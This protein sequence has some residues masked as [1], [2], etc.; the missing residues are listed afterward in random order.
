MPYA[1]RSKPPASD[2]PAAG[3]QCAPWR[4]VRQESH[5]MRGITSVIARPISGSAIGKPIATTTALAITASET[6][7]VRV[8]AVVRMRAW[9]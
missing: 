5:V 6:V 1:V 2:A 9:R 8:R 7:V 3:C 4:T